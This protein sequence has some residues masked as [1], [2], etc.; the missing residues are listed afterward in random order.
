MA[1]LCNKISQ[2]IPVNSS[3]YPKSQNIEAQIL[4][5]IPENNAKT[6]FNKIDLE[7]KISNYI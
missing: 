7:Y 5:E 4:K 6:E 3:K 1:N 2:K